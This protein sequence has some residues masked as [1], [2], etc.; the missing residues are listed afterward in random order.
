MLLMQC[1]RAQAHC[2]DAECFS[3]AFGIKTSFID[4]RDHRFGLFLV[5]EGCSH[6]EMLQ[7]VT[8][9][10][11]PSTSTKDVALAALLS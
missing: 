10:F 9:T 7:Q 3:V 5:D 4:Y 11:S 8:F 1:K 6:P 2:N